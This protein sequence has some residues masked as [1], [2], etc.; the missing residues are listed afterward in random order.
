M[1]QEEPQSQTE[2]A[3]SRA[4]LA[5]AK[6]S[7][8]RITMTNDKE[9]GWAKIRITQ[10]VDDLIKHGPSITVGIT[11]MPFEGAGMISV[12]ALIDTGASGTGISPRLARKLDLKPI[13]I[14]IAREAGR[15]PIEGHY[16][17]V[18]LFLPAGVQIDTDVFGPPSVTTDHDV[19]IG[20]DILASCRLIVDFVSG[21]TGLHVQSD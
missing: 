12:L 6:A 2:E 19:L 7:L 15:E 14:G 18:R 4:L 1:A 17:R 20:R 9:P 13:D 3:R 21:V 10:K 11:P 5:I 8:R 16:F